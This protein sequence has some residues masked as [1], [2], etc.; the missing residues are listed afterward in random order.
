MVTID[1]W[2]FYKKDSGIGIKGLKLVNE[3]HSLNC[4]EPLFQCKSHIV[5]ADLKETYILI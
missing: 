2:S 4:R 5:C 3:L 1:T